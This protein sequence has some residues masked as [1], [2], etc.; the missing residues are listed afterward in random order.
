MIQDGQ[1]ICD[2]CGGPHWLDTVVSDDVWEKIS[3]GASL[4]CTQCIDKRAVSKGITFLCVLY[5]AGE[6]GY[7][8]DMDRVFRGHDGQIGRNIDGKWVPL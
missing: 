1:Q 4:L 3:D 7:N 5:W 6:A 2:G 8:L